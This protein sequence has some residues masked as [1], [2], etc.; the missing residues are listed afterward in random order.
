MI[1]ILKGGPPEVL[2]DKG[3]QFQRA[4][5]AVAS[6]GSVDD[7][8]NTL[9]KNL[10]A[11]LTK[12]TSP[13]QSPGYASKLFSTYNYYS[14]ATVKK[15]LIADQYGKCVFCEC[16]IRDQSV[17]DVEHFFPK[18]AVTRFRFGDTLVEPVQEHP[19][20]YW[21]SQ[22]W[23]NLFLSCQDCNQT[24]KKN[25]FTML[26]NE[27]LGNGPPATIGDP[28]SAWL[29]RALLLYPSAPAPD[30]RECLRFDPLTGEATARHAGSENPTHIAY[31]QRALLT[32]AIVGLNRPGL[33]LARVRHLLALF[34]YYM[35]VVRRAN[36]PPSWTPGREVL[37]QLSVPGGLAFDGS[38]NQAYYLLDRATA[39]GAEFSALARDAI[40][41]WNALLE[42][43]QH[44]E[45]QAQLS[46]LITLEQQRVNGWIQAELVGLTDPPKLK[47]QYN[48]WRDRYYR[49]I[50]G[51]SAQQH[52]DFAT[53]RAAEVADIDFEL[54]QLSH[55]DQALI[56]EL[57]QLSRELRRAW[58]G[59]E[60]D[61]RTARDPMHDPDE[62]LQAQARI[63]SG[64]YAIL[65]QRQGRVA[66]LITQLNLNLQRSCVLLFD[67]TPLEAQ[68][69]DV[70]K[71]L[72][73][74]AE[75]AELLYDESI[76]IGLTASSELVKRSEALRSS[77]DEL[78]ELLRGN[79]AWAELSDE[80][81]T[82]IVNRRGYPSKFNL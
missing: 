48:G 70:V 66:E 18:A 74:V 4:A 23:E 25:L 15:Q 61:V 64:H 36:L 39:T 75:G 51:F 22:T 24:F 58:D 17:G 5:L 57:E 55:A 37:S 73:E 42:S 71:T 80:L 56:A 31:T 76:S 14:D 68:L 53:R 26:P 19:G 72:D 6:G 54:E 27:W 7:F 29:P 60:D 2:S 8:S 69:A 52:E 67:Q 78:S 10:R 63:D 65:D 11:K 46:R 20:F 33:V 13:E 77:A 41:Y 28:L 1:P 38:E 32:I 50:R 21:L 81:R 62:R 79:T 44:G 49:L 30:P 82:Q 45:L 59:Y 12:P 35:L 16:F 9:I 34:S 3:D 47:S 40:G 43:G